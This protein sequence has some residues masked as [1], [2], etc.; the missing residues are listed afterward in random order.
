MST[1]LGKNMIAQ[2]RYITY[3]SKLDLSY[4]SLTG[5]LSTFLPDPHPELPELN[6]LRLSNTALNKDDLQHLSQ[7]I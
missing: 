5:C 3:L 2:V 4:N 6:E 7:I 1:K